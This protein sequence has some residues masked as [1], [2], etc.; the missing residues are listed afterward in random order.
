MRLALLPLDDRP[1][2]T[3]FPSRLAEV[4]GA[5]LL[6]PP[7]ELLGRF[8]EPG[9]PDEVLDW[10]DSVVASVDAVAVCAEMPLYGGLVASRTSATS[11]S[12]ALARAAR[13]RAILARVRGPVALGSVIMRGTITVGGAED[14]GRYRDLA[15]YS[16]LAGLAA[17]ERPRAEWH[18][19]LERLGPEVL[20]DYAAIRSRNHRANADCIAMVAEGVVGFLALTQEDCRPTGLHRAEQAALLAM[21]DALGLAPERVALHPGADELSCVLLAR[22]LLE[23]AGRRPSLRSRIVPA[24]SADRVAPFEDRP[25]R[26]TLAGQLA[27]VGVTEAHAPTAPLLLVAGPL[28]ES[29]DLTGDDWTASPEAH[30]AAV[31]EILDAVRAETGAIV[32]ADCAVANGAWLPLAEALRDERLLERLALHTAWNTAGNTLGTA[33]AFLVVGAAFGGLGG[34]AWARFRTERLLD[35][36]VYQSEVRRELC[37]WAAARGADANRLAA[38]ADPADRWLSEHV[39]PRA[40][41]EGWVPPTTTA[42]VRLPWGRS[43]E[44]D[45]SVTP[46]SH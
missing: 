14:L 40:I 45:V 32:L 10:L 15:R 46:S 3:R 31:S 38:E 33:V 34:E 30:E 2:H 25:I 1:C 43:F 7:R 19:L 27:S 37:A 17:S 36:L 24:E 11:E 39:L 13:L 9:R 29:T 44:C 16:E 20:A 23:S 42:E 12:L 41:A 35:D 21:R 26:E 8:L 6:L 28:P 22:V 5:E 4:A 18:E